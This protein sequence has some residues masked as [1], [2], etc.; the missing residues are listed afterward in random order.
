M[1]RF[2]LLPPLLLLLIEPSV[3]S[4]VV[5]FEIRSPVA[6]MEVTS[7]LDG[8]DDDVVDCDDELVVAELSSDCEVDDDDDE[9]DGGSLDELGAS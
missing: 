7:L 8:D 2:D 1:A 3:S 5:G 9:D 6:S 4:I